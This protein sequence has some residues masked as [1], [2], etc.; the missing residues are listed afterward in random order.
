MKS[1]SF[2]LCFFC[3]I[4]I[5]PIA[6]AQPLDPALLRQIDS[7]FTEYN[8]TPPVSYG[9][10]Y[11]DQFLSKQF[12]SEVYEC[13]E[14]GPSQ[15]RLGNMALHFT[16]YAILMLEAE[17]RIQLDEKITKYLGAGE[18]GRY[19]EVTIMHLLNHSHGLPEYW[20]LKSLMGYAIE[21]PFTSTDADRI[22][23]KNWNGIHPPGQRVSLS[24]TGAYLLARI[25]EQV[26]GDDLHT[27]TQKH[28]FSPLKME[29]TYFTNSKRIGNVISYRRV[30]EVYEPQVVAHADNGPAGIITTMNDLLTWFSHLADKSHAI[31]RKIDEPIRFRGAEIAEI[32]DGM[33]T[34]GQQFM[35]EERGINKIWD[36]GQMGGFAS[37][38][39]R[40]PT[41][42]LSIIILSKNG[43]YFNGFLGMQIS[44]ILLGD[45]YTAITPEDRMPISLHEK[46]KKKLLGAYFDSVYYNFRKIVLRNDTLRYVRPDY[47]TEQAIYPMSE[48]E[49]W[50][51]TSRGDYYFTLHGDS[52]QLMVE[53]VPYIYDKLETH[54]QTGV[55]PGK[56]IGSY[57]CE[58]LHQAL[59]IKQGEGK[60]LLLV[61][62]KDETVLHQVDAHRFISANPHYKFLSVQVNSQN[63][64][65]GVWVSNE[66]VKGIPFK[67]VKVQEPSW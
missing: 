12:Q 43:L 62:N 24:G 11:H 28:I 51:P 25:I 1:F 35:H 13:G 18:G 17:G 30:G 48:K 53:N 15:F 19:K 20:T 23:H 26:T 29:N 47:G 41:Y 42:D 16:A 44:D 34:Y 37:A 9:I 60:K 50:M 54:T 49:L 6:S 36:Y 10:I 56:L 31:H 67:K 32:P 40:F 55:D 65:T 33:I 64:V 5:F 46:L 52:L 4:Y 57:L 2:L 61:D 8:G 14:S 58:D 39:Y 38:V 21:D 3:G 45:E 22:F 66:G 7:L 59:S 27:F 63:E